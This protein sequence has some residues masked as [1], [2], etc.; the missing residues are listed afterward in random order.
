MFVM[1]FIFL[2]F[3]I[4]TSSSNNAYAYLDA[5]TFTIL[6]NFFIAIIS[7]I[8][9]YISLFWSKFKKFIEKKRN[10]NDKKP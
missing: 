4:F 8:A 6:I 5:G 7:G 9:A 1:R 2:V 3:I 10:K